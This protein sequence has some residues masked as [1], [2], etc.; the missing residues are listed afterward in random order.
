MGVLEY[1]Q[2]RVSCRPSWFYQLF[3]TLSQGGALGV[4]GMDL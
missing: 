2:L 4:G 1:P 3:E